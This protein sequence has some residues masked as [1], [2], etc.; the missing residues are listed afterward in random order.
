MKN[1]IITKNELTESYK[2]ILAILKINSKII[3]N[4]NKNNNCFINNR[5]IKSCYF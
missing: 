4:K 2:N 1:N 3:N 5:K